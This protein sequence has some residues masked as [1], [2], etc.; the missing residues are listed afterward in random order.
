MGLHLYRA[1]RVTRGA[2]H[3]GPSHSGRTSPNG[4]RASMNP[5]RRL[6]LGAE[7]YAHADNV[8]SAERSAPPRVLVLH[9]GLAAQ[10]RVAERAQVLRPARGPAVCGTR[11]PPGCPGGLTRNPQPWHEERASRARASARPQ[12]AAVA[13][14]AGIAPAVPMRLRA[15]ARTAGSPAPQRAFEFLPR[16]CRQRPPR[17]RTRGGAHARSATTP[18]RPLR[19]L[20]HR[21]AVPVSDRPALGLRALVRRLRGALRRAQPAAARGTPALR[22]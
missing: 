19:L 7:E 21:G 2:L 10:Q 3:D 14:W 12:P 4:R 11:V 9:V 17:A 6:V 22:R 16:T 5:D 8:P 18:L 15:G 20:R 1:R 13:G